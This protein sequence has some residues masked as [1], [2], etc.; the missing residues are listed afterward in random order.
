MPIIALPSSTVR[1]IGSTSVLKDG[2]SVVKELVD[3]ALDAHASSITVEISANTVDIIQVKDNGHGIL[4]DDRGLICRPSFTSKIRTIDDLRNVGGRTLGF[5]GI[6]LASAADIC[7]CLTVT[8]RVEGEVV[9]VPS[10]FGR[11]G[12][13]LR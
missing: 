5:R 6:A 4:P 1:A 12:G 2:T 9:A 7:E 13:F 10:K 8:T 3:N 11:D